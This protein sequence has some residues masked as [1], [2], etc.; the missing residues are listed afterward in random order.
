M[1]L[2][3]RLMRAAFFARFLAS[4]PKEIKVAR[5]KVAQA[6]RAVGGPQSAL[7]L[8]EEAAPDSP[9]LVCCVALVALLPVFLPCVLSSV[10]C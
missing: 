7:C 6:I 1:E 5:P 2:T 10:P 3:T 4:L 8:D 9:S